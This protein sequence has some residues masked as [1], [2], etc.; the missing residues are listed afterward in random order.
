M[1]SFV[2]L[3]WAAPILLLPSLLFLLAALSMMIRWFAIRHWSR[4]R[5]VSARQ[6]YLADL[7]RQQD[8]DIT[9]A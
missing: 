8:D 7:K 3:L 1:Q 2:N 5:D 9:G 6:R 4:F